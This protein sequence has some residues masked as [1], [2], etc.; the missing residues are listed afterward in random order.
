MNHYWS[1]QD[2]DDYFMSI[3]WEMINDFEEWPIKVGYYHERTSN[4]I[5][6][7]RFQ[8]YGEGVLFAMGMKAYQKRIA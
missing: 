7:Q 5:T 8:S 4:W 2:A 6:V 1:I 3:G